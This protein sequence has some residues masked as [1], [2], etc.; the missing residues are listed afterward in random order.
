MIDIHT[1]NLFSIYWMI[2][3]LALLPLLLF[4]KQPYGRHVRKGWGLT[5]SNKDAWILMEIPSLIIIF[6]L[7]I[8][9][10]NFNFLSGILVAL[11]VLHYFHRTLIFPFMIKTNGKQMP[12]LIASFGFFFNLVNASINGLSLPKDQFLDGNDYARIIM[13]FLLFGTGMFINIYSDYQLIRLR[14]SSTNGYKVPNNWLF[15]WISCPNY[16]GEIIEWTGFA[17][18]AWNPAALSFAVWTMVNLIPR[19]IDHHSWYKSNF[20]EYPLNRKAV[21]PY[22][23]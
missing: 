13:G 9:Y 2:F 14:R 22:I 23:L 18:M 5:M 12:I 16:F 11:W 10:R 7:F 17:I 21:F 6:A 19:A 8:Y 4:V 20:P 15:N 1:I 3:A